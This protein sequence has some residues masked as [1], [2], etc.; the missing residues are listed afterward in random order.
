LAFRSSYYKLLLFTIVIVVLANSCS[1]KKNSFTRRVY[2]NL[3]GHY[4]MFWNGRESYREGVDQLKKSAK[5]NYNEILR[6]Y[7][8]GTQSEAQSLNPFMDKAIEKSSHNIEL[9]SMYFNHKEYVRWIDDS[10]MLIGLSYFYKQDYNKAR[11]TF[12]FVSNEYKNNNI[13][14]SGLLWL[15]SSYCQL[16]KYN[17]AQSVL[18][19][20]VSEMDKDPRAPL[21]VQKAIPLVNAD[22]FILQK[23]YS[24]AKKPLLDALYFNQKKTI[25]LRARFIL[26]Q[27]Y[28]D[29]GELYKASEY[30]NEVIKK[31]PP[32]E[33]AFNAAINLAK[34][35]DARY[36]TDSKAIVRNLEKMLKEDKNKDFLD[37]I[38]Y[39]LADLAEKDGLDTL[40][41][42]YLRLSVAN[43]KS[44]NYQKVASALK[45]GNILFSTADYKTAQAYYDT[46]VQ[47]LPKDYPDYKKIKTRTEYLTELVQNLIVIETED[48]LQKLVAMSEEDRFAVIDKIIEELKEQEE[49]QK[50]LDEQNEAM[51][52]LN[53]QTGM[54]QTMGQINSGAWYFY[55]PSTISYGSSE[56]KKKWG[57]R[58]L[59]DN[60][61]LSNKQAV[62]EVK[63]EEEALALSDSLGTDS[64]KVFSSDAHTREY[65]LQNLPFTDSLMALS[66][67]QVEEA[68]YNLG[69]IYKDK[70]EDVLKSIESFETLLSRFPENENRLLVYYELYRLY[71]KL[72]STAK[73]DEYKNLII[74]LYPDSDYA[75]LILD[76]NFYRELEAQKNIA[77]NLYHQ[78]Y[79][80]YQAGNYFTSYSNSNRALRE[81]DGP[82]EIL[83]RFE[84]L[85]ALSLGKI[86][87]VDSLQV[88]LD[89]LVARYPESDVT[90]LAQNILNYLKKPVD[91]LSTTFAKSKDEKEAIDFSIYEFKP[92]SKQLFAIVVNDPNINVNALKV[93][94]SDFNMKYF[95][96]ENISITNILLNSTTHFIMVGNFETIEDA[97]KYYDAI[98]SN[99]YVFASLDKN[100][101]NGFILAQEN[102]PVFYKDKD[103]NKYLAFFRQ[104][105][106]KSQ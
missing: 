63:K 87:V 96:I 53:P 104:N 5:D 11:R 103:I 13:R 84:Y 20:L 15:A 45:L 38:Y 29:E 9:H 7:N 28:Q 77:I 86:E 43:S 68:F 12:E 42:H 39:A 19:N 92:D 91:S 32:Y 65:Y 48:S 27:I 3:T 74:Q 22:I 70:L 76:P 61:R 97:M 79:E 4:N 71:T 10:Y 46:A 67:G 36:G 60:W 99:D 47:V 16:E 52:A 33:M 14:Y 89:S 73:A 1:T 34:S 44:N 82:P 88:A 18:E 56:F 26:G 51:A 17:R 80:D 98:M 35:Y 102:Y 95:S 2:H 66:N 37:Q 106:L 41:V 90:P 81:F 24:L 23:K 54:N 85:R 78:T 21:D 100:V 57:G 31:N 50:E 69:F 101:Y 40:T 49:L 62:F 30:Y 25:D 55:N 75:K 59:E 94:I 6:V 105:Y 64:T 83:A 93:R 72:D 8:F 58:K